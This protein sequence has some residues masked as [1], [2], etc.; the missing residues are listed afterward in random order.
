V[1]EVIRKKARWEI[2][3]AHT[4][5]EFKVRVELELVGGKKSLSQTA[6]NTPSK[7]A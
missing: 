5:P 2:H 6:G 1:K 3:V 7:K 4:L